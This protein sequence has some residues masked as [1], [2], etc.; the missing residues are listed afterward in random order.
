MITIQLTTMTTAEINKIKRRITDV[1]KV[2]AHVSPSR[3]RGLLKIKDLIGK[4]YEAEVLATICEN[5]VTQEKLQ[6]S[7]VGHGK[8]V[9]KQKGGPIN[10]S[11]PY[12][13]VWKNGQLFAELFTD[14]YFNT[15]S[16]QRRIT[17][18]TR[19][20]DYHE[21]DIALISPGVIHQP[22]PEEIMIAVEC[23]NTGVRKNLIRELL[24]FR[25]ELSYLASSISTPFTTWPAAQIDADP[26]SVHM[27]FIN[28]NYNLR[29]YT[30]NCEV[31]GIMLLHHPM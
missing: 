29:Q 20:G 18:G 21:L 7:L 11:F 28:S 9:L 6:I 12:F 1:L 15:L 26:P 10:R 23:K 19:N 4:L 8:L 31:F 30:D 3:S 22:N 17:S 14:I 16:S 24:G 25:R 2:H 13:K 27:L 5:L